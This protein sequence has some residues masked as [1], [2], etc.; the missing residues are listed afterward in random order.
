MSAA[1]LLALL[2]IAMLLLAGLRL[3]L[4]YR[5]GLRAGGGAMAAGALLAAAR[6]SLRRVPDP[7]SD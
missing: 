6:P 1:A 2:V 5:R 4:H 7:Y 3:E